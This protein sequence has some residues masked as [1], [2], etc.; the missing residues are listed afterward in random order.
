[1]ILPVAEV[2]YEAINEPADSSVEANEKG[3]YRKHQVVGS[4]DNLSAGVQKGIEEK[5]DELEKR[6]QELEE[7]LMEIKE[8]SREIERLGKKL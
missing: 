4:S 5:I 3:L 8:N 1:M 6:K 2:I 7:S